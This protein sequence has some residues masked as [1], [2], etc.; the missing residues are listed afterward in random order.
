MRPRRRASRARASPDR[1]RV[2]DELR[3]VSASEAY[4][5]AAMCLTATGF[6]VWLFCVFASEE[7]LERFGAPSG[8]ALRHYARVLPIWTFAAMMYAFIGYECLNLMATPDDFEA[9]F[10][11]RVPRPSEYAVSDPALATKHFDPF[12]TEVTSEVPLFRDLLQSEITRRMFAKRASAG[13][14]PPPKTTPKTPKTTTTTTRART[15]RS[16][17]R[18]SR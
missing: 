16:S 9:R 5:F 8:R 1:A 2:D 13:D 11:A 18:A 10:G 3:D 7:T 6:C 4:G 12:P 14:E 17:A 15:T